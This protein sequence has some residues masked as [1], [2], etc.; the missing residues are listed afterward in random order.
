MKE[1]SAACHNNNRKVASNTMLEIS[2]KARPRL[3]NMGLEWEF[4][5]PYA[6]HYAGVWERLIGL[7]KKH[8]VKVLTGNTIHL[9]TFTTVVTLVE[10]AVNRRPLTTISTD[11]RD[12]AP[13][14]P[15]NFLVPA[16]AGVV[17]ADVTPETELSKADE[18]RH[19][20]KHARS[21]LD[22]F[23]KAWQKDYINTLANRTKWTKTTTNLAVDD[24]VIIVDQSLKRKLWEMGRIVGVD[25]AEEH[26]RKVD[27]QRQ[28]GSVITRDRTGVVKL[29]LQED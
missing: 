19:H 22:A 18:I 13:L 5:P 23:W 25:H 9:D 27:I 4:L 26:V 29:E 14:T 3:L 15:E 10:A 17:T 21:L 12:D 6:S 20:F 24:V 28:D 1:L 7:V 16:A 2:E 8:L 11:P